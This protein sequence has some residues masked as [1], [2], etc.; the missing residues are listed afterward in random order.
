MKIVDVT[1]F[2]SERGG[3]VRAYLTQLLRE[4]KARG[5]AVSVIAPGARDE[6]Q[7]LEGGRVVRLR[8][9]RMPYD[10]TY[11]ALW[12]PREIRAAIRREAP[13]VLQ[14]S[15]PYV[16]ALVATTVRDVGLRSLVIHSDFI[17]TY[18]RPVLHRAVGVNVANALLFPPWAGLRALTARFS[19][20][21]CAGAWLATK[22]RAHGCARVECVPFGIR[23]A[24][25]SPGLR[26]EALRAE[27]LDGLGLN[28]DA[29]LAV[30]V[31]RLAIEK[32]V[33][34]VFE[35][36]ASLGAEHPLGVLVLG[37]GPERVRLEALAKRL[38]LKARFE[39]FVTDRARYATLLAS[40]DALVHGCSCETFGFSVAEALASGVPAVVPDAGGA[41]EFVTEA[42]GERYLA[43]GTSV[44]IAVATRRLLRR[45][46]GVVAEAALAASRRVG[47][48]DAHFDALFALYR[49]R[50]GA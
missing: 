23:H 44:D 34:R 19:V 24:E 30:V 37:D 20:T 22:L 9:P 46:R 7:A 18:A 32:R 14:A 42:C 10:P 3:G 13:D 49:G 5:H 21:V 12:N 47:G 39:G 29:S 40:A 33:A 43:E 1:E 50:L 4:G 41:A 11:H 15:S 36:L 2:W 26:D 27:I 48:A 35:A 25:L 28:A 6:V 45:P 31:G 8:G 16:A 38:G 17:D